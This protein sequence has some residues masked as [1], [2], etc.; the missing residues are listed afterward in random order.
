LVCR[1]ICNERLKCAVPAHSFL[2]WL[3]SSLA[4]PDALASVLSEHLASRVLRDA[5]WM[6]PGECGPI[7]ATTANYLWNKA[8]RAAEVLA[9]KLHDLRRFYASGLIAPGCDVVTVQR[10]LGHGK[11]TT[12]LNTYSHLWPTAEDRTRQAAAALMAAVAGE[13]RGLSAAYST[14]IGS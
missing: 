2:S 4:L 5:E 6:F 1:P 9:V 3:R 12:T 13:S 10:A 14:K 8:R 7:A 11:P